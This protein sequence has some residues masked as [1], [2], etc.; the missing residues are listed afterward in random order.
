[1]DAALLGLVIALMVVAITLILCFAVL[2]R[3]MREDRSRRAAL[4]LP[5][6]ATRL[7]GIYG[8]QTNAV[9]KRIARHAGTPFVGT[10]Q[11]FTVVLGDDAISFWR[12]ANVPRRIIRIPVTSIRDVSTG[13]TGFGNSS[14]PTIF[15][16]VT[17]GGRTYDLQLRL[18]NANG[19]WNASSGELRAYA[20]QIRQLI[21][22]STQ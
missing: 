6:G 7:T 22:P 17:F 1:M 10:G 9:L 13:V 4:E 15:L 14:F 12:G 19:V 2:R 11:R 16:G 20:N 8:S 21:P 5:V 18:A 3:S